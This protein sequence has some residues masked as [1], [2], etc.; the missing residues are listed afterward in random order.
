MRTFI[1]KKEINEFLNNNLQ[2]YQI[3][4]S[5]KYIAQEYQHPLF[6]I[7]VYKTGTI[8]IDG[9]KEQDIYNKFIDLLQE[10]NYLGLD[11]V[12]VGDFFGPTVYAIVKLTPH[13]KKSLKD[14]KINI[15]DS[16]KLKDQEIIEIYQK[17]KTLI[18]YQVEIIWDKDI[19]NNYNSIEQ[20]AYYHY[21]NYQK[22][23][24]EQ[25]AKIVIDLFTTLN[26]FR[27]V[28]TKLNINYP[29]KLILENQADSKY[30]VVALASIIARYYFIQE[31][32]K[33]NKKY[34]FEFS[35]G[36]NVKKQAQEFVN[37]YSKKELATFCKITFKTFNELKE[38][39]E[40]I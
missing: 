27:K 17:I 20:K 15:K 10:D 14:L 4:A 22:I 35:Y 18:D 40:K 5:T 39:N 24:F 1:G 36:A 26:N 9:K 32:N 30:F 31:M 7:K 33:L 3:A 19:P 16:K 21:R 13:N 38:S 6:K 11:E 8:T 34:N 23:T 28:S 2:Q 12:G 29:N 25:E 37:L